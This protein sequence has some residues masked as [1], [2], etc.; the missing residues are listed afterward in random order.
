VSAGDDAA[1][2]CRLA[3]GEVKDIRAD[4]SMGAMG[5]HVVGMADPAA[6]MRDGFKA[7]KENRLL[8]LVA[9]D[10]RPDVTL[11]VELVKAYVEPLATAK[12]AT[13]VLRV[14]YAGRSAAGPKV[15]RG[16][17]NA[18]NWA[19]TEGEM[20]GALTL[21]LGEAVNQVR[22]DATEACLGNLH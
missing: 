9:A 1:K 7:L 4:A 21:A 16:V 2:S 17:H 15:Y 5:R 11:N 18:T 13:V 12:A 6:W 8:D 14:T 20:E 10:D 3:V 19:N 22:A